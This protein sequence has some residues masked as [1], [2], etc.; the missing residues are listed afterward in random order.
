LSSCVSILFEVTQLVSLV[1]VL[2]SLQAVHAFLCASISECDSQSVNRSSESTYFPRTCLHSHDDT[3][4]VAGGRRKLESNVVLC[5]A[6][7]IL[8]SRTQDSGEITCSSLK[9]LRMMC[10]QQLAIETEEYIPGECHTQ[11]PPSRACGRHADAWNERLRLSL[12]ANDIKQSKR[13][14][15]TSRSPNKGECCH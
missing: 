12:R 11:D 14:Q 7:G 10:E 3:R 2:F 5:P 15:S 1:A 13:H 4:W 6:S 8:P 9:Y